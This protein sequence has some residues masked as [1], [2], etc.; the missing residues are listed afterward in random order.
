M[1]QAAVILALLAAGLFGLALALTPYG[2]RYLPPLAGAAVSIP[3]ATVILWGVA[4]V[5]VDVSA[6]ELDAVAVFA[7]VGLLFPVSVTL[8]TF[9][10]N[11]RLGAS[12]AGAVGNLAPVFAI[13]FGVVVLDEVPR[14]IQLLGL[15]IVVGGIT[16]LAFARGRLT[17]SIGLALLLPL[18]AAAIRGLVQPITRF[19]LGLWAA[20]LAAAAIGYTVSTVVVLL[21]AWWFGGFSAR[22][23]KAGAGWF[24][25]VGL[26]NAGAVLALYAAL[27]RGPVGLVAPLVGTYPLVTLLLDL[28]LRRAAS[29]GGMAVLGVIVTVT[30]IVVLVGG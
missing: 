6:A 15:C 20:P 5:L 19:G 14:P 17:A 7:G 10:A 23:A 2:L 21:A 8:L 27:A 12:T 18:A 9:L 29:P 16:M 11:R 24:V 1:E 26:C 25:L 4:A 3:S 22:A 13:L 28:M 30:G